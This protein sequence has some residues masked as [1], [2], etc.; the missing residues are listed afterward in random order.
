MKLK[1]EKEQKKPKRNYWSLKDFNPEAQYLIVFG[2][3]CGKSYFK[4]AACELERL[5]E[6]AE[7]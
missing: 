3:N 4:K 7:A 1:K 2:R 5:R 6:N